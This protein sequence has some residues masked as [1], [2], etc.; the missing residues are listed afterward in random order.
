MRSDWRALL[1]FAMRRFP[2][3][4]AI[5]AFL[6]VC[7]VILMGFFGYNAWN[8]SSGMTG[9]DRHKLAEVNRK[10]VIEVRSVYQQC[11]TVRWHCSI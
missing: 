4:P 10:I 7:A 9:N 2:V 1:K 8:I 3:V 5:S 6:A 11:S